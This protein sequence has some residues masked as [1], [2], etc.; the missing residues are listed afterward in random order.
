[1]RQRHERD[2]LVGVLSD[3]LIAGALGECGDKTVVDAA[4]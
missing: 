4:Y 1:M 3:E 2:A